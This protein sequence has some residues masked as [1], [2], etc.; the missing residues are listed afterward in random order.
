[1]ADETKASSNRDV[2]QVFKAILVLIAR[3]MPATLMTLYFFWSL[4]CT[5]RVTY[6]LVVSLIQGI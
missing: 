2:A 3:N 6:P 1:M 4:A 5:T